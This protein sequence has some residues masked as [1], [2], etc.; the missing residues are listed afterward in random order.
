MR[1]SRPRGVVDAERQHAQ[2]CSWCRSGTRTAALRRQSRG[3]FGQ[4]VH[5]DRFRRAPGAFRRGTGATAGQPGGRVELVEAGGGQAVELAG[6]GMHAGGSRW[7]ARPRPQGPARELRSARQPCARGVRRPARGAT[8]ALGRSPAR[9]YVRANAWSGKGLIKCGL[10]RSAGVRSGLGGHSGR[11]VAG[12][13]TA[14]PAHPTTC[15]IKPPTNHGWRRLTEVKARNRIRE[16][17]PPGPDS[18]DRRR[19]RRT[20]RRW[21]R[22]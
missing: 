16:G 3:Q 14:L 18:M 7:T 11:R 19:A 20:V 22:R 2:T 17:A 15:P 8:S 12:A 9:L 6:A 13:P 1:L 4:V 21:R 5:D 10:G